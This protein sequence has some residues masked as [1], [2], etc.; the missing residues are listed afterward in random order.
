[1]RRESKRKRGLQRVK[2]NIAFISRNFFNLMKKNEK[3]TLTLRNVTF[4]GP[5]ICGAEEPLKIFKIL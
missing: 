1:M 3:L 5:L 4:S 2:V